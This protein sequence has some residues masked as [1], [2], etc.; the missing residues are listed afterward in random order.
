MNI[1]RISIIVLAISL[2]AGTVVHIQLKNWHLAY[3]INKMYDQH[4][5]LEREYWQNRLE[6]A[7][8]QSP[9][10]LIER[11]NELKLPLQGFGLTPTPKLSE[12]KSRN[13]TPR[14]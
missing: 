11:L 5:R 8:Y 3:E 12:P 7:R 6:L 1:F 14:R 4:R 13:Q 10:N 2:I 9:E